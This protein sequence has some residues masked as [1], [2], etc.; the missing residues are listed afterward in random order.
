MDPNAIIEIFRRNVTEHYFDLKG[1]V[2]RR[3]FWLFILACFVVYIVAAV[4]DAVIS[5]GLVGAAVG[6]GLLLPTTGLGA[7]RL[8]DIGKNGSMVWFWTIPA[9]VMQVIALLTAISGPV[10]AL[11]FLYFFLAI[12][13]LISLVTL[14]AAIIMIY[15]WV[16]PGATGENQYGPPPAGATPGTT[17]P[18]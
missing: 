16:Q 2:S 1:R 15:L 3:E 12:G 7:R 9:A 17:A 18:A 13:W 5:S 8:Q 14:V 11:G 6:L 10:G 4:I